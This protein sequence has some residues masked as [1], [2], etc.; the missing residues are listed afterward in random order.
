MG[1]GSLRIRRGVTR[2]FCPGPLSAK[3][4]F[5]RTRRTFLKGLLKQSCSSTH[6]SGRSNKGYNVDFWKPK[7]VRMTYHGAAAPTKARSR[8]LRVERSRLP[9]LC[10]LKAAAGRYSEDI[11]VQRLS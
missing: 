5:E 6:V 1:K 3:T 10:A 8:A 7:A 11:G 4:F 2:L 9:L